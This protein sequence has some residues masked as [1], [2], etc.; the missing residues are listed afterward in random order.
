MGFCVERE[1][2]QPLK[3]VIKALVLS[4][5]CASYRGFEKETEVAH[6]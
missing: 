4:D 1:S 3:F 2:W 6:V 5:T